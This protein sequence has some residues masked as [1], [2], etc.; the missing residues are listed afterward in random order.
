VSPLLDFQGSPEDFYKAWNSIFTPIPA[1][2]EL[3]KSLSSKGHRIILFSNINPIHAPYLLETH[4]VFEYADKAAF[5]FEL[6]AI[7]PEK[8]FF[9][10]AFEAFD[11]I[12]EDTIYIDD[13]TPASIQINSPTAIGA[14]LTP[15]K[16]S[17]LQFTESMVRHKTMTLWAHTF[18]NIFPHPLS[19]QPKLADKGMTPQFQDEEIST[20]HQNGT[21]TCTPSHSLLRRNTL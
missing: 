10:R 21:K 7:K 19:M 13:L 18:L 5:S 17:L 8:A 11:I 9:T 14:T 1:T 20:N 15:Q 12:P 4:D 6:G 3:L 16:P 2:W